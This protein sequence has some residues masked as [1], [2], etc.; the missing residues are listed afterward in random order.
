MTP[1]RWQQIE[2]VYHDA[3]EREPQLRSAYVEAICAGDERV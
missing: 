1:E 2:A 3:L